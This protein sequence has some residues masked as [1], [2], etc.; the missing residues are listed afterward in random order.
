MVEEWDKFLFRKYG[1]GLYPFCYA[2]ARII[3]YSDPRYRAAPKYIAPMLKKGR[4]AQYRQIRDI[5]KRG[6]NLKK[7]IIEVY[8]K[9]LKTCGLS[10]EG[11]I[12]E[13]EIEYIKGYPEVGAHIQRIDK[14]IDLYKGIL[15][16]KSLWR[17][18]GHPTDTRN[19]IAFVFAQVIKKENGEPDW[20]DIKSLLEWLWKHIKKADYSSEL[21]LECPVFSTETLRSAHAK[22]IKNP[23]RKSDIE[24]QAAHYF[25][26]LIAKHET[27]IELRIEFKKGYITMDTI[28]V[29]DIESRY[30]TVVFPD[31]KILKGMFNLE[32][33]AAFLDVPS[34]FFK[35]ICE[36][37]L[38]P[39]RQSEDEEEMT[40]SR[41]EL[42]EY[43]KQMF[44]GG[45]ILK[46]KSAESDK[47]ETSNKEDIELSKTMATLKNPLKKRSEREQKKAITVRFTKDDIEAAKRYKEL[48]ETE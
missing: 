45:P 48:T 38:V 40:F 13:M 32:E 6:E 16:G 25:S 19:K 47:E 31:G 24:S 26:L 43:K 17:K 30:P 14:E 34:S 36:K 20:V 4:A 33:A 37:G 11:K 1:H 28:K 8:A 7:R 2:A 10:K 22:F 15:L 29:G 3:C 9:E 42:M 21:A 41:T 44:G 39:Y 35:R 18:K 27:R 46:R 12:T 23:E 5:I